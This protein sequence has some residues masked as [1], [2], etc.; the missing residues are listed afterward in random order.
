MKS[1]TILSM[2][3]SNFKGIK[4]FETE[5]G[6]ETSI[7]AYNGLGKST[8]A[9]AFFWCLW[10]KDQLERKDHEI[11]NTVNKE[12]NRQDHEVEITFD[13]DGRHIP[14]K[15]VYKETRTARRGNEEGTLTGH[16]THVWFDEVKQDTLKDFN[17]KV[18]SIL[19][20]NLFKLITNPNHFNTDSQGK[21]GW[22]DRRD[23]LIQMAGEMP[24]DLQICKMDKSFDVLI[25]IASEGKDMEE[26]KKKYS[27]LISEIN[28]ELKDNETRIKEN[29]AT[30]PEDQDWDSLYADIEI[31]KSELS[32]LDDQIADKSKVLES[33]YEAEQKR[34]KELNALKSKA[35]NLTWQAEQEAQKANRE[36]GKELATLKDK[37]QSVGN[38]IKRLISDQ[39][40]LESQ[41]KSLQESITNG[42][43]KTDEL[44]TK[45]HARN[46]EEFKL[47]E[48]LSCTACG[49]PL[50]G[51]NLQEEVDKL[52]KSFNSK[53]EYDLSEIKS[54]GLRYSNAIANK[55]KQVED[56][57]AD[58]KAKSDK[59]EGLNSEYY[60]L[61][62]AIKKEESTPAKLRA[63]E[64]FLSPELDTV[65][66]EIEKLSSVSSDAPK[67]DVS[68]LKSNKE[69]I[70]NEIDSINKT[71][72]SFETIKD[73]R[74]RISELETTE[75]QL[76]NQKSEFQGIE[77]AIKN[78]LEKKMEIVDNKV[79]SN[80]QLV[81]F[82]LFKNI[83][84]TG[85]TE[86]I[87]ET[88][89][90]GVP[91]STLNTGGK[92]RAGIDIINA[93]SNYYSVQAPMILDN[94][95][96]VFE[97]PYTE[98]QIINLIASEK[99]KKKLR[100]EVKNQ[101]ATV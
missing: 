47:S 60:D 19:P 1:I 74:A 76:A 70:Q 88:M 14:I 49:Q 66:K 78:F 52:T 21:W 20:E 18:N 65:N 64:E 28:K 57:T 45:W 71:L 100:V 86:P 48:D 79:N 11:K 63:F 51:D 13:V 98:N 43:A 90:D 69:A 32:K 61:E 15:R 89:L 6:Q 99:D 54:E 72:S 84:S 30:M 67:V 37:K 80:F 29:L 41:I 42:K 93:F 97:I 53:K 25:E 10:G 87:C 35:Q 59:Q 96:S 9:D 7:F 16:V 77:Y 68:E 26:Q 82:K 17:E 33:H 62:R 46:A 23:L 94:R 12:L 83:I 24:S 8:I 2:K 39:E 56:L 92:L 101:F 75:R 81:K 38:E 5:F 34:F 31:K 36:S 27:G 58:L 40:S 95:E 73:K 44:R 3:I 55:E 91:W 22:K 50:Q 85:D 4:S